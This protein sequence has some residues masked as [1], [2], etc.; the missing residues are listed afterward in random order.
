MEGFFNKKDKNLWLEAIELL[1]NINILVREDIRDFIL[2]SKE[3]K[4]QKSIIDLN[5]GDNSD[6]ILNYN[7]HKDTKNQTNSKQS[8]SSSISNTINKKRNSKTNNLNE[9][10]K[11]RIWFNFILTFQNNGMKYFKVFYNF[12]L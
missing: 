5:L 9:V 11:N 8:S 1:S 12:I 3:I 2:N 7:K 4:E 10:F 6:N